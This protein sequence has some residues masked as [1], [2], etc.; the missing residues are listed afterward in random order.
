MTDPQTEDKPPLSLP[1]N[2]SV[3]TRIRVGLNALKILSKDA[4]NPYYAPIL[5]LAFD[6]DTY[7]KLAATL[8]ETPEGRKLLDER[9]TIP[10]P[11]IDLDKLASL[12]EGTLGHE[13]AS[14]F[15]KNGIDVFGFDFALNSDADYLNKRYRETHDIHHIITGYGIDPIG[16]I[17]LQAFYY[18]N[19]GLRHAALIAFVSVPYEFKNS[20]IKGMRKH[21]RRVLT[22]YRRGKDSREL[23]SINF[24]E[25]WEKPVSELSELICAPAPSFH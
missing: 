5:H 23:L 8:R 24:D 20:G 18:G 2:A 9:R 16:E 21:I 17:E 7:M 22:A 19:L 6:E 14:Y 10:G 12:P 1:P 11:D 25:M 4:G 13:F 15:K 3:F